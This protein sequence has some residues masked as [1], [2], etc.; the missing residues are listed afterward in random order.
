MNR[1]GSFVVRVLEGIVTL[2]FLDA[3]EGQTSVN[4]QI[5]ETARV[6]KRGVHAVV[7]VVVVILLR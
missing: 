5:F 7:V 6:V 1:I 4:A 2:F 3:V